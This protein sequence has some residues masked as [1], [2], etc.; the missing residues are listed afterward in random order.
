MKLLGVDHGKKRVGVAISDSGRKHA[1]PLEAVPGKDRHILLTR[2][3]DL[4]DEHDVSE[5]V[6]GL[7]LTMMGEVGPQARKVQEFVERLER[8]LGPSVA[9]VAW[10]ERLSS[11]QADRGLGSGKAEEGMRD[12]MAAVVILQSYLDRKP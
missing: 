2:L 7:P 11:A 12:M 5:V 4:V 10:D 1:F 9:V 6:V 8:K 3:K